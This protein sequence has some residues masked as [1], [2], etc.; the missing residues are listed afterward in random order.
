VQT[1]SLRR[2]IQEASDILRNKIDRMVDLF[3]RTHP[4]FVAGYENA[5]TI[6]DRAATHAAKRTGGET[7]PPGQ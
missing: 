5:R 1:E 2:M 3:G 7:P 4:A 6:V